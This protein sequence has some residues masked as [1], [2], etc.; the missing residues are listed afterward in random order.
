MTSKR[1][2]FIKY[3]E[4]EAFWAR[5]NNWLS[6]IKRWLKWGEIKDALLY[7]G[8]AKLSIPFLKDVQW[9]QIFVIVIAWSF[10][11]DFLYYFVGKFDFKKGLWKTQNEW[12]TKH[13]VMNPFNLELR[14]QLEAIGDKL[15]I[16]SKF[17]NL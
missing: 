4:L 3:I 8:I 5:G 14:E 6:T 9:W 13:Q 16:K 12:G 15:G 17:K 11:Q 7:G 10:F 1:D 2:W